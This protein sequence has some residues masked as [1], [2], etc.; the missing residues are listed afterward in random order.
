MLDLLI[1]KV[2]H[3]GI[4]LIILPVLR[5]FWGRT[6]DGLV[7]LVRCKSWEARWVATQKISDV[8]PADQGWQLLCA[9]AQDPERN[10]REGAAHGLGFLLAK[11]PQVQKG[12]EDMLVDNSA[13]ENLRKAVLHSTVVL[14]RQYPQ[15][16][17]IAL[18]LLTMA[19]AQEPKGCFATIGSYLL[20]VD[21]MKFHSHAA[22]ALKQKWENSDNCYLRQHALRT[23]Q[24]KHEGTIMSNS[25]P[26]HW[27][28]TQEIPLSVDL[29]D[30]VIGQDEAVKIIR[31]A[32]RQRRFVL[33]IG[34][35]GTGKSMLAR[36]MADHLFVEELEDIGAFPN[37]Q[38]SVNPKIQT[39]KAGDGI[40]KIAQIAEAHKKS[41]FSINCLW[42][43]SLIGITVSGIILSL[44]YHG[45]VYPLV[46]AAFVF[47]II[48]TRKYL[49]S[50]KNLSLPKLLISHDHNF[51]SSFIEATG[52][53]LGALLGD[54]R[55]DPFQSGGRETP[56]HHLLEPGAIHFAHRGILFIDEV[57][58]FNLETQQQLLT[59]IQEKKFPIMGRSLGSSGN[60]VR[61]AA[62][63][64]DFTLVLAGNEE[65]VKKLHPGLRSRIIGFGYEVMMAK[66][67]TDTLSNR[68]KIVQFVVQ[69]VK[70]DGRI[71]HFSKEA[72]ELIIEQAC[73]M[74]GKK[75]FISLRLRELG[76]IV[77][78]AGDVAVSGNASVVK[79]QHVQEALW[80]KRPIE[81][82]EGIYKEQAYDPI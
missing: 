81:E 26:D 60:M 63:P 9:L 11:Y 10:V 21:L 65:D 13:P 80:I 43:F 14:W 57:S 58:S 16:L 19:A 68:E 3:P 50:T 61:S 52:F 42:W 6:P 36:A 7:R 38:S 82:R 12:Y 39:F 25:I 8:L 59:A 4:S 71:P 5:K 64:C 66:E 55:H 40:K 46:T 49:V 15:K 22:M 33:L 44:I 70:K 75:G 51:R 74:S 48:V 24:K 28:T 53:Q 77:R 23:I 73:I 2:N 32:A 17:D 56:S 79:R 18:S 69:E 41:Q 31:L 78:A 76:G 29:L 47:G 1:S 30:Q 54:V 45:W 67:M 35:P 27:R 34:Q 62:V 72:V 37:P 20:A